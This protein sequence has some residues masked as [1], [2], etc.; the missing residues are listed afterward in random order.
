MGTLHCDGVGVADGDLE[1]IWSCS[2]CRSLSTVVTDIFAHVKAPEV[3][4]GELK[5]ANTLLVTPG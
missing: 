5:E 4:M 3:S 2:S 1:G